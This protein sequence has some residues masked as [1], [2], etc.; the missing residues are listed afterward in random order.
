MIRDDLS[1]AYIHVYLD[2]NY[3]LEVLSNKVRL[4]FYLAG[5]AL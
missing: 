3:Y 2:N 4:F 5:F 1:V